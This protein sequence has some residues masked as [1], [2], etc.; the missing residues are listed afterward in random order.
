MPPQEC[1]PAVIQCIIHWVLTSCVSSVNSDGIRHLCSASAPCKT[2][3]D[4]FSPFF[5]L[6]LVNSVWNNSIREL[7]LEAF[8]S[9]VEDGV[10]YPHSWHINTRVRKG[11]LLSRYRVFKT[12]QSEAGDHGVY[13]AYDFGGPKGCAGATEIAVKAWSSG[14]DMEF[15]NEV[16]AYRLLH[17]YSGVPQTF[18]G[19]QYDA[20]CDVHILPMQKLGPT[21]D[22]L[23]SVLPNHRLD[24]RMV[25]TVAIQ[26]IERYRDIHMTGLIHNG[27]KPANICL[28]P[29]GSNKKGMLYI[30][31]F[32]FALP[33]ED[34][35]PLPSAH[36]IDVVGNR[37]YMSVL[38]HHGISKSQRDDLESLAYLLS[39]LFHGS[40]P[41]EI[42]LMTRLRSY[43][44]STSDADKNQNEQP[45]VW[46][47]KIATPASKLFRDMDECFHEFWRDVKALA[48]GEMPDYE[49]MRARF[50]LCLETHEKGCEPRDWWG[51]WDECHK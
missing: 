23:I 11:V 32:G 27:T 16:A 4:L 28:A 44:S 14:S 33:L 29:R 10:Y 46:R 6:K 22:D 19:A 8:F 47:R 1:P 45:Q 38:A 42:P 41:W 7:K 15:H 3:L 13:D 49:K 31:D 30:I 34:N 9:N 48:Y 17:N 51:I 35:L 18:S 25:L 39:Y 5:T 2:A 37:K 50:A 24:A 43:R 40:L 12:I 20:L 36:R 26:M 21:L